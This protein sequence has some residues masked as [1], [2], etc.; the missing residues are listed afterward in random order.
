MFRLTSAVERGQEME[1]HIRAGDLKSITWKVMR[2]FQAPGLTVK[3]QN[4]VKFRFSWGINLPLDA[5]WGHITE[6]VPES[7]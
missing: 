6:N 4:Q 7:A 2:S 5:M 1:I 3:T